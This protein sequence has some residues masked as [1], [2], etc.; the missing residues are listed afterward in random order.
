MK[1]VL[2]G[3]LVL[4]VMLSLVSCTATSGGGTTNKAPEKASSPSPA[5][6][7]KYVV[8]Y[9]NLSWE[10]FDIEGDTLTYDLY[11]GTTE[12]PELEESN[13]TESSYNLTN[14]DLSTTY[15]WRVD[16]IDGNGNKTTGDLWTFTTED[17]LV[18]RWEDI[19]IEENSYTYLG[20][21][22]EIEVN[23]TI[24]G[25]FELY[26]WTED[27]S[28]EIILLKEEEFDNFKNGINNF[29]W[30]KSV[31]TKDKFNYSIENVEPGS[32]RLIVDNSDLGN[33]LTDTDGID[34]IAYIKMVAYKKAE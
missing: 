5:N 18:F 3:V 7:D 26:E 34:D 24:H 6:G 2:M 16:T 32:Y 1:K 27:Y 14:L 33:E 28:L 25:I 17:P 20:I 19:S 10:G 31:P 21:P 23:S 22:I 12:S 8:Y 15:Y 13:L 29:I 11:F 9:E 4:L 30:S